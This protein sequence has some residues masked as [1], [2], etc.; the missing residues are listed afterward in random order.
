MHPGI[1]SP[2]GM[3]NKRL[4]GDV[5]E[6][7]FDCLLHRGA[8]RLALPA[9]EGPAIPFERQADSRTQSRLPG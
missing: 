5:G 4:A 7:G 1:G 3:D 2:G 9:H 8:V 6:C